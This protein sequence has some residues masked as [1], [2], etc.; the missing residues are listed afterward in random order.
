MSR[1]EDT[2]A[3][4]TEKLRALKLKPDMTINLFDIAVPLNAAGFSQEEIMAILYALEQDK[5]VA[6]APGNRIRLLKRL[7]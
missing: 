5:I 4:V 1:F 3:A 6:F 2:E 7:P